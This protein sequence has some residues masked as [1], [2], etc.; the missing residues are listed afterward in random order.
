MPWKCP[1]GTALRS[2]GFSGFSKLNPHPNHPIHVFSEYTYPTGSSITIIPSGLVSN[3]DQTKL[4]RIT[5]YRMR[6]SCE[7]TITREGASPET[8]EGRR[9]RPPEACRITL[10]FR[11][12]MV[13]I[14]I[15]SAFIC[16]IIEKIYE[17]S[18]QRNKKC[19]F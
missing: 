15:A 17:S 8:R 12:L 5:C 10:I 7:A 3:C 6:R 4:E 14:F 19:I 2:N 11:G 9:I 16:Y 1:V 13:L 18:F